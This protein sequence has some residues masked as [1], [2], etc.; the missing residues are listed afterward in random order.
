[1]LLATAGFHTVGAE[2]G[3]EGA[4]PAPHRPAPGAGRAMFQSCSICRCRASAAEGSS[5]GRSWAIRSS[6]TM[7]VAKLMSGAHD[8]EQRARAALGAV[9]TFAK[10]I[11]F[12]LLLEVVRRYCRVTVAGDAASESAR[13]WP[14]VS[15][16]RARRP[17]RRPRGIN[18]PAGRSSITRQS[19]QPASP[20]TPAGHEGI[21]ESAEYTRGG[22]L[23]VFGQ[24][25]KHIWDRSPY[26]LRVP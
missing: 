6:R 19:S 14:G 15:R 9:A 26:D 8:V 20:P 5:G 2:D 23:V 16:S 24:R 25:P 13:R 10:P 7:P 3:L 21:R 22:A 4:A 1:M 17:A 12:D 18:A 11:D